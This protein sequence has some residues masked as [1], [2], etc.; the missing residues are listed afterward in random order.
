MP[1]TKQQLDSLIAAMVFCGKPSEIPWEAAQV[2]W[3][4]VLEQAALAVEYEDR[5]WTPAQR[6]RGMKTTP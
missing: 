4:Y 6:I 3:N 1:P 5:V 2:A